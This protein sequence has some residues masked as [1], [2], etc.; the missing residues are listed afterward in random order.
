MDWAVCFAIGAG[1]AV[2]SGLESKREGQFGVSVKQ[3]GQRRERCALATGGAP[4]RRG[5][6]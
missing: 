6:T 2:R 1:Y 4:P 3:D 5:C